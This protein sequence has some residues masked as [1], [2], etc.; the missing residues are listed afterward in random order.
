MIPD[1]DTPHP[2]IHYLST[3][4]PLYP[5]PIHSRNYTADLYLENR[6]LYMYMVGRLL[7]EYVLAHLQSQPR[8]TL[9]R[10]EGAQAAA[11]LWRGGQDDAGRGQCIPD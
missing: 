6:G 1:A 7:I 5:L 8:V 2:E 11:N 9:T 10:R 4:Y 3:I